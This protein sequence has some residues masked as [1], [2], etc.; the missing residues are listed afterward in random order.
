MANKPPQIFT[1]SKICIICEGDEEYEYLEK[2]ISLD[3]W[4]KRYC[5]QLENAATVLLCDDAFSEYLHHLDNYDLIQLPHHGKLDNAMKIFET[6]KDSYSKD[7]LTSDNTGSGTISGGSD[8][9]V[10]Y[11]KNERYSPVF[12]TKKEKFNGNQF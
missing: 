12:N 11:M 5:F 4:S 8:K 7:Y 6:L 3:A 9:L 2:L 10:K 1:G